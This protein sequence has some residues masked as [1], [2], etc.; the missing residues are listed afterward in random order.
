MSAVAASSIMGNES[1]NEMAPS[2]TGEALWQIM[3]RGE[4]VVPPSPRTAAF[5][6]MIFNDESKLNEKSANGNDVLASVSGPAVNE[7]AETLDLICFT[8][9][10]SR[11]E[12]YEAGYLIAS[13]KGSSNACEIVAYIIVHHRRTRGAG[14]KQGDNSRRRDTHQ[15]ALKGSHSPP[16]SVTRPPVAAAATRLSPT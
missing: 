10:W 11:R 7:N 4:T 2:M 9:Y 8:G 3:M 13:R 15:P 5:P 12:L 1:Q 14:R 6:A 16:P